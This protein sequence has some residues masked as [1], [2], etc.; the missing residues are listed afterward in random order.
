M[1]KYSQ[2]W[3]CLSS[4]YDFSQKV[5]RHRLISLYRETHRHVDSNSLIEINE[6]KYPEK[7]PETKQFA[8]YIIVALSILGVH[9]LHKFLYVFIIYCGKIKLLTRSYIFP[10]LDNTWWL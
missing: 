6:K 8:G 4:N 5:M 3:N 1:A 10:D 2:V 9:F 7:G